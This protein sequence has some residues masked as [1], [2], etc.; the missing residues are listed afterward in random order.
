VACTETTSG[1]IQK[2][3][4]G[5]DRFCLLQPKGDYV[6][7]EESI[8]YAADLDQ[9]SLARLRSY[10]RL[11]RSETIEGYRKRLRLYSRS[12]FVEEVFFLPAM[13]EP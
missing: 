9:R 8:F 5:F 6:C 10:V 13:R 3:T 11:K 4:L 1:I 7:L 12:E 2:L